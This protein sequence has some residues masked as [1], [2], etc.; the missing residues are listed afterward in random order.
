MVFGIEKCKTLSIAKGKLEIRNF[1]TE[2]AHTME[3][4][5]EDDVYRYL[6]HMK[7]KQI[8]HTQMKQKLGEEYLNRT[9][10]ILKTKLNRKKYDKTIN[11][12]VTPVLTFSYGILK[13]TPTDSENLQ[14]KTRTLLAIYRFNQ[15]CAAKERITLPRQMGGKGL[16]D[17]TR[18][19]DKQARLLQTHFLN[20][21]I[22][23]PLHAAV[24]QADDR[25]TPL[26]LF[27]A[28]E[29]ELVT[30]EE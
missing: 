9:K 12:Y 11:T 5:D 29:N 25:Y 7:S 26:D 13:W 24:V 14:T 8:S 4:M 20:K 21:Q 15:P 10:S 28:N 18:L 1:T 3:A 17:I 16:T 19:R 22:T 23:S 2:D 27:H 6:G 30:D